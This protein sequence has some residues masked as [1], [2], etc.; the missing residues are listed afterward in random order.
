MFLA[1]HGII[2]YYAESLA[3][4]RHRFIERNP[5]VAASHQAQVVPTLDVA[6][7]FIHRLSV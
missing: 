3:H 4:T 2:R 5:R 7:N 6:L 1:G